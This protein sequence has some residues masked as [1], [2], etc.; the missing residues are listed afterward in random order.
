[1]MILNVPF[2]P[3]F[4]ARY[5]G[6]FPSLS[7]TGTGRE[8]NRIF[9]TENCFDNQGTMVHD[10]YFLKNR[11]TTNG[12]I[13]FLSIRPTTSTTSP[14]RCCWTWSRAWSTTSWTRSTTSCTTR[15]TST[16]PRTAAARETTGPP[17]TVRY[18]IEQVVEWQLSTRWP[19]RMSHKKWKKS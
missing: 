11:F 19:G 15:R 14:G 12:K 13:P 3:L 6:L 17:V 7:C 18:G 10:S 8:K 2:S 1:M 16:S 5:R 4:A 9:I